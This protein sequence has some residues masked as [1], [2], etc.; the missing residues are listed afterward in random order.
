MNA[1]DDFDLED[2]P[3]T[4]A[5]AVELVRLVADDTISSKQA[6]EV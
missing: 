4:P 3:L 6:K 1:H 5:R 2:S